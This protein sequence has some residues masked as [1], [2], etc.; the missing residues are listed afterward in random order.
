MQKM[1]RPI[2]TSS[3]PIPEIVS[4]L[5][6]SGC[7]DITE[8]IELDLCSQWSMDGG[9]QGDIYR[10]VLLSGK[11][12]AIKISRGDQSLDLSKGNIV[13][14]RVA[15]ELHTWYKLEHRNTAK[16]LGMAVFRGHIAMVSA[17]IEPGNY[18]RFIAA[19]PDSDRMDLCLQVASGL[20]YLHEKGVVRNNDYQ[21]TNAI[22][23]LNFSR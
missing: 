21:I 17:W 3:T 6:Q 4:L 16:L 10:G 5:S 23:N 19:Y 12:V 22:L 11:E 14:K 9:G 8:Q 20:A 1:N 15:R 13:F 7:P 18:Y 2:I